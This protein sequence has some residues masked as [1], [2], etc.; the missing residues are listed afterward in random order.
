M[1]YLAHNA[2]YTGGTGGSSGPLNDADV[3]TLRIV[4]LPA[5]GNA[6]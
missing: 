6:P 1:S 2:H 4:P 5:T 3:G